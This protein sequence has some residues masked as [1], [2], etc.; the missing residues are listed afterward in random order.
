MSFKKAISSYRTDTL[1]WVG[2]LMTGSVKE[3][4]L[5]LIC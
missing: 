4:K 1:L 3:A 5:E 2:I